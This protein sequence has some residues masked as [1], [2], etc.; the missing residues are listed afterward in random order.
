MAFQWGELLFHTAF[1][2]LSSHRQV[3]IITDV[4][5]SIQKVQR[6]GGEPTAV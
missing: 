6:G 1:L 2:C 3:T 4:V 5:I